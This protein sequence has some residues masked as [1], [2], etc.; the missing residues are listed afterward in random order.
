MT[1]QAR[2]EANQVFSSAQNLDKIYQTEKS[3][4]TAVHMLQT[5]NS[6]AVNLQVKEQIAMLD[7][8]LEDAETMEEIQD[9][10]KKIKALR[11]SNVDLTK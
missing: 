8:M 1:K 9:I 2:E 5:N 3:M 10:E 7:K 4:E 6:K 11:D